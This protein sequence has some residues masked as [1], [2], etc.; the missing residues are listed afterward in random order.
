MIKRLIREERGQAAVEYAL[1][2]LALIV[3]LYGATTGLIKLQGAMYKNQ[4]QALQQWQ[5]P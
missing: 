1:L 3:G 5:A 2:A 4:H